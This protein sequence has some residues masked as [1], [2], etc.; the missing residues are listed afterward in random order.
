MSGVHVSLL[1]LFPLFSPFLIS[2]FLTS[3][4]ATGEEDSTTGSD[5]WGEGQRAVANWDKG[6]GEGA[7]PAAD[8]D[9]AIDGEKGRRAGGGGLPMTAPRPR[10][11]SPAASASAPL[12]FARTPPA[13][14]ILPS[15]LSAAER[16]SAAASSTE[17]QTR[18]TGARRERRSGRRRAV[19]ALAPA[20]PLCE[21]ISNDIHNCSGNVCMYE[22]ST[23]AGDTGGKVGTDTFAVGTA[24]ANLAFGCVVA[25]NID[26]MDGSSGIVGLGRTPWS[27][28]TQTG[29][30]AFSYCLAPHDAGKNN[31]LFLGSTAKLAGGGK[32]ASTPF[33][34]ISGND[35]SN[36]YKVQL[37]VLKA[38]DAMI[39]L[40]PSGVL[41]DNYEVK[42]CGVLLEFQVLLSRVSFFASQGSDVAQDD[43]LGMYKQ[44][45]DAVMCIL[46]PDSET[47]AFTTKGGLLYVAEWN[48][49]Q[50]P[51][52]SAFLAAVYSDYMQ[53][54]RKTELT[55]SGQGFSPS[56]LRKFAK[57][58][59]DY[60]L[61]SNPMKISYLVGY[62]DRYPERVHHRGIS[63]PENVDTGCDSHK[64][65][66]TSKPNPNVT[67]DALVGGLYKNNSFVDERDNVMHNEATTYN[68]ALVA[69][70]LSALVSTTSLQRQHRTAGGGGGSGGGGGGRRRPTQPRRRHQQP[71]SSRAPPLLPAGRLVPIGCRHRPFSLPLVPVG[72]RAALLPASRRPSR[73]PPRRQLAEKLLIRRFGVAE[74]NCETCQLKELE[75]EPREIKDVLRCILH[76]IFFHRTLSLVRPKD[77]DC[78][79]FEI[80]YVSIYPV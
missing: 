19:G 48:S 47:A 42:F 57:S 70:L 21:S 59:A 35:L 8:G 60:L 29:V 45:A 73:H 76:T 61:G 79:F 3:L 30:A 67:T 55:C 53:S 18:P 71:A 6:K 33:V 75:L 7:A 58:Q 13:G 32:T 1:S 27:L 40:P 37:E 78:D 9:K 34:N 2:L 16:S 14:R 22:A 52:A 11:A 26:T 51:V 77:F 66:E 44:T 65:L 24:K 46:L 38:G 72:Q 28:V 10:G 39:P 68:C 43:V 56:D 31:A 5:W 62:G 36:Y 69:G 4:Q 50:H 64:W 25:S 49:L 12:R 15:A 74:M 63:I 20:S 54:S 23:N 80:T 41:W 17:S